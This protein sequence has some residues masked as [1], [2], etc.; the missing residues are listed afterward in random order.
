MTA[1]AGPRSASREGRSR[2]ATRRADTGPL[3]PID[4]LSRTP[5]M[6]PEGPRP[7]AGPEV[8][9]RGRRATDATGRPRAVF[10]GSMDEDLRPGLAGDLDATFEALVRAH[11][12]RLF[13]LALRFLGDAADAE[14]IVPDGVV[15]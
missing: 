9:V 1:S 12:D 4:R 15:R 2:R 10:N 14:G 6:L 5:A 3:F 8:P 13:S 7:D 11:Q